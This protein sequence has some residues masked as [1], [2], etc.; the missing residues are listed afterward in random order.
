MRAAQTHI[1]RLVAPIGDHRPSIALDEV[2]HAVAPRV[3]LGDGL[4]VSLEPQDGSEAFYDH[5][6]EV[7]TRKVSGF[8]EHHVGAGETNH[9]SIFGFAP[10]PLLMLL[11]RIIGDKQPAD[12]YERHRHTDSW[13]WD[14]DGPPLGW[15]MALPPR[16][17]PTRDV[18]LLLSISA[19]V[20]PVAVDEV[21]GSSVDIVEITLP[22]AQRVPNTV[23][24][25]AQLRG[26]AEV[27]RR[28]LNGIK[29]AYT[30][31]RVH[32]FPAAPLSVCVE[33]GRRLLPKAD[34]EIVVYDRFGDRF[35]HALT[36]RTPTTT[37]TPDSVVSL[38]T[39]GVRPPARG[40][41]ERLIKSFASAFMTYELVQL[42]RRLDPE[43]GEDLPDGSKV[44][45]T[46]FA[47]AA[48]A[49]LERRGLIDERLF[50]LLAGHFERGDR[51]TEIEQIRTAWQRDRSNRG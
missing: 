17:V 51:R 43:I 20:P 3:P 7:L 2:R 26:F 35:V 39:P 44:G 49:R 48:L 9:L 34:P 23:R 16:P 22:A 42:L 15:S 6:I 38:A 13:R 27:W 5:G 31:P 40:W 29:E 25:R 8:I 45:R 36:L 37:E 33:C 12:V 14:D 18:A 21:L 46:Q 41:R 10:M 47:D 24:T 30:R 11:G 19:A 1:L 4:L 50:T 32:I 28:A